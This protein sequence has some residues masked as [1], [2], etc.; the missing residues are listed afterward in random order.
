MVLE[1]ALASASSPSNHYQL[2]TFN[3]SPGFDFEVPEG[4][5]VFLSLQ[6]NES[7]A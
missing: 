5:R 1:L 4:Q 2:C 7:N 6:S 3:F